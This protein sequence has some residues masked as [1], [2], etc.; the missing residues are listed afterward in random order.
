M[1]EAAITRFE[2]GTDLRRAI[3]RQEFVLHYQ[4][5]ID[6]RLGR[7]LGFEALVRWQ[8][9]TRGLLSPVGFIAAAEATGLIVPIGRWV[10]EEACRQAREWQLATNTEPPLTM[11]A[12]LSTR[13]L[14]EP[15]LVRGR[16]GHPGADGRRPGRR[17]S[18]R[19]PR[20]A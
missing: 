20:P 5:V 2:L 14:R 12:N 3:D 15:G 17:W 11:S 7:I 6:L 1:R 10:L 9:P 13:E 8:H 19:S 4:P 16:R 18:S